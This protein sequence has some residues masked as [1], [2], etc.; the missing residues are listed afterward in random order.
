MF[1]GQPRRQG[2]V[3]GD[4]PVRSGADTPVGQE[5]VARQ[6]WSTANKRPDGAP[7]VA[8]SDRLA[9]ASAAEGG[10]RLQAW[11]RMRADAVRLS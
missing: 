8:G 3:L 4:G 5:I 2:S 11:R 7:E 1:A 10:Q 6:V 9:S